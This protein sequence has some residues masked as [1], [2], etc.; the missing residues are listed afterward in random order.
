MN[1]PTSDL[2]HSI[3]ALKNKLRSDHSQLQDIRKD[4]ALPLS[5][6]PQELYHVEFKAV[7]P[8]GKECRQKLIDLRKR[9]QAELTHLAT[10]HKEEKQ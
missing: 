8:C 7:K 9:Q 4:F 6:I 5:T 1:S 3:Q 10:L 2:L